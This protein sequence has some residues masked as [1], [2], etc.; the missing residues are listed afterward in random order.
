MLLLRVQTAVVVVV[1]VVVD[2]SDKQGSIAD[3]FVIL[4]PNR[5]IK[6][7]PFVILTVIY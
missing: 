1:V 2:K 4:A 3:K 6:H 7:D 5:V